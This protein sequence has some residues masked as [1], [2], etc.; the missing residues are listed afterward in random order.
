MNILNKL[1]RSFDLT[2]TFKLFQKI[3][4]QFQVSDCIETISFEEFEQYT[5][6]TSIAGSWEAESSEI[7]Q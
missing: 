4:S 2:L 7:V 5:E 6:Q 3:V 1:R